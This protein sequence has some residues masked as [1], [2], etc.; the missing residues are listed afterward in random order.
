MKDNCFS[1]A[2]SF[3]QYLAD[4]SKNS[5]M[6]AAGYFVLSGRPIVDVIDHVLSQYSEV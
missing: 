3:C 1:L 2:E 5:V 6:S 4:D